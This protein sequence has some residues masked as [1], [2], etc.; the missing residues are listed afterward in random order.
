MRTLRKFI[1]EVNKLLWRPNDYE[2]FKSVME[3]ERARKI[4]LRDW[5]KFKDSEVHFN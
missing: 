1:K 3:A 5:L 4:N 2:A